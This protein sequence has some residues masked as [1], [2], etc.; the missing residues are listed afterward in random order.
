MDWNLK[1]SVSCNS[2]LEHF[3]ITEI[4]IEINIE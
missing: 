4:K 1:Q 3:G 2:F